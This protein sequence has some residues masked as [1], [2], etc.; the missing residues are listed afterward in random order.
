MDE[1]DFPEQVSFGADSFADNPEPRCPC[2][3]LLDT[4]LSMSGQPIKELNNGLIAFKDEL[5][6]DSLA[7]KR[8]EVAIVTFGPVD[9]KSHFCTASNFDPPLLTTTGNTPLGGAIMQGIDLLQ[10]RKAEYR[11]NGIAFY[12]PWIFLITDGAPTD[13]WKSA[14]AAVQEGENAKSFAFFTVG[15]EGADMDTLKQISVR[16][17]IKLQGLKFRELFAWLS[18]SMKSV[19]QSVPGDTFTLESPKGWAEI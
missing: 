6:T 9:I 13:D 3:L 15:V 19:S 7:M 16:E 17:P 14:A 10:Q 2:L 8:V 12:R 18:N 11:S 5:A 1:I 4:S